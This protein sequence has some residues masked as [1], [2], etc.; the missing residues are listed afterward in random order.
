MRK[1]DS[2]EDRL[3]VIP[4]SRI[5]AFEDRISKLETALEN[6][7]CVDFYIKKTNELRA[8]IDEL[9]A[10]N[11]ELKNAYDGAKAIREIAVNEVNAVNREIERMRPVVEAA[12]DEPLGGEITTELKVALREY[13][14]GKP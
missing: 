12:I 1:D 4:Q 11:E 10:E 5:K 7:V 8:K 14:A 3:Q 6:A 2:D 13:E 9:R